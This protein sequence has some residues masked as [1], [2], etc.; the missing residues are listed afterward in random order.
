L[1]TQDN[2]ITNPGIAVFR[3]KLEN[4]IFSNNVNQK[5]AKKT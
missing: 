4:Y 1:K 2:D 5:K 3:K